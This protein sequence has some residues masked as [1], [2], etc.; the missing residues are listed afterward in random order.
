MAKFAGDKIEAY[1]GPADLGGPDDLEKVIV[2]FIDGAKD[3]LDI[4]VQELDNEEI[5]KAILAAKW[6]GVSV[7]IVLEQSYLREE[8]LKFK[9]LP[10]VEPGETAEQALA[11][12]QWTTTNGENKVNRRIATALFQS[13]LDLKVDFNKEIFHQKFVVRDYRGHAKPTSALLSGSTNFT[14]TDCHENLNHIFVFHDAGIC[15]EYGHQFAEIERG[16]FG[17]RGLGGEPPVFDL[18]GVPVT[19]LFAPDNVPEQEVIKQILKAE[20]EIEFAIFTFSGSSAIDDA[21]L[22]AARAGC[23]VKGALD[24]GQAAHDWTAPHGEQGGAPP[25]LHRPNIS[26][27]LPKEQEESGVRK[28]HHKL[29]TIDNNTVLAGSFNYTAPANRFNDENLFVIGC[30]YDIFPDRRRDD[31]DELEKIDKA[32][33]AKIVEYMRTEIDRITSK[34]VSEPWEP[35]PVEV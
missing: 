25:W 5:A 32:A 16:E 35:K 28:L 2:D 34:A 13:N 20:K 1:V 6:R 27:Y 26:L 8:K 21:L 10:V 15:R 29:M 9:E 12:W 4:A 17:P 24:R 22:M 7:S 31:D 11:K 18:E 3:S 23:K 19:V 30:A 33:T 14:D